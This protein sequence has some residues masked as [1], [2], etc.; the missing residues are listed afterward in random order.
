MLTRHFSD[1]ANYV[2]ILMFNKS[3]KHLPLTKH[4]SVHKVNENSTNCQ[5][6]KGLDKA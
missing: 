2:N 4:T 6:L 3:K 1:S 5:Q